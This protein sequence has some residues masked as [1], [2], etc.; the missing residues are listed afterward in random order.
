MVRIAVRTLTLNVY[1]VEDESMLQF[2]RDKTAAP[3]FSNL[4]C[5]IGNH[6]VELNSSLPTNDECVPLL[7]KKYLSVQNSES[8]LFG[9]HFQ[10]PQSESFVGLG[11]RAFGSFTL[12][13]RHSFTRHF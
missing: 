8:N 3:Y 5:F 12:F 2:I 6:I 13:E 10:P 4:A 9:S 1:R 7:I 11:C